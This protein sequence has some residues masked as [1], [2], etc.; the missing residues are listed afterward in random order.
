MPSLNLVLRFALF[1][2][3]VFL[4][5]S[6]PS[7]CFV[8]VANPD[9]MCAVKEEVY[10]FF[11]WDICLIGQ[12]LGCVY[13]LFYLHTSEAKISFTVFAFTF[14]FFPRDSSNRD[15]FSFV[16]EKL[17]VS[18]MIR[19]K[20]F[21]ESGWSISLPLHEN[22]R[23]DFSLPTVWLGFG[24]FPIGQA[25]V[26][27]VSFKVRSCQG[28]QRALYYFKLATPFLSLLELKYFSQVFK[29]KTWLP[30]W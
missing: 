16:K 6:V 13:C 14:F 25:L 12:E 19:P 21:I 10:M 24:K 11:V 26:K 29:V 28:E 22:L 1:L 7:C 15:C 17:N 23:L 8:A 3:T 30:S 18:S 4:S 2:N 27:K 9:M 20:S 5:F